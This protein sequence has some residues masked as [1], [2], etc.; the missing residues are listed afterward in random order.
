M[1]SLFTSRGRLKVDSV[2]LSAD[3]DVFFN[4]LDSKFYKKYTLMVDG[5]ITERWIETSAPVTKFINGGYYAKVA[6]LVAGDITEK[7]VG[8]L[9]P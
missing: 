9:T 5:D 2:T 6:V 1:F 8:P 4:P 3:G 7:W